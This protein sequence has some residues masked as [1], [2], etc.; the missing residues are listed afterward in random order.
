MDCA[1][2]GEQHE[3]AALHGLAISSWNNWQDVLS[4]DQGD[5]LESVDPAR[6]RRLIER[7]FGVRLAISSVW[8]TLQRMGWSV[9]RPA[10]GARPQ[11]S[12]A[13]MQWTPARGSIREKPSAAV[14]MI[15]DR[16]DEISLPHASSG[17]GLRTAAQG[18]GTGRDL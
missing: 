7:E 6:I 9:H 8:R 2:C 11:N 10:S 1:A 12:A 3:S 5:G 16:Q 15:R 18:V 14:G 17:A 4:W 13:V